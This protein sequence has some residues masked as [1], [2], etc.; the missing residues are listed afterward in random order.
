M[1]DQPHEVRTDEHRSLLLTNREEGGI[2]K[3]VEKPDTVDPLSYVSINLVSQ[4]TRCRSVPQPV[5]I[6]TQNGEDELELHCPTTLPSEFL[7]PLHFR[8][9]LPGVDRRIGT[10]GVP[11]GEGG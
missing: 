6:Q 2:R 7:F 8:V 11:P 10:P 4:Y 3:E 9:S 5:S 1:L